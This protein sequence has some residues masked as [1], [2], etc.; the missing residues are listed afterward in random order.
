MAVF[1]NTPNEAGFILLNNDEVYIHCRFEI[2]WLTFKTNRLT[3]FVVI[4]FQRQC[5]DFPIYQLVPVIPRKQSVCFQLNI[6]SLKPFKEF[7]FYK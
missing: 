4:S 5:R 1:I 2:Q 6:D 7:L 3:V